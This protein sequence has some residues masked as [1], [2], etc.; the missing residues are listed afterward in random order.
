[1]SAES[2]NDQLDAGVSR[3]PLAGREALAIKARNRTLF[4]LAPD[5]I[6]IA[7]PQSNY[8]DANPG[9]CQ[10]LGYTRSELVGMHATDIVAPDQ[11]QRIGKALETIQSTARYQ[12]EWTFRRKD[13]SVFEADVIAATM[14]DGNLIAMVRDIT[15]QKAHE[16]EIQRISRLYASLS[17]INQAIVSSTSREELLQTACRVLVEFGDF[18][19]AWIGWHDSQT[20]HLLPVAHWGDEDDYLK[21]ITVYA[22][23]RSQ[24]CGPAGTAF[25]EQR[26]YI[27]D[28]MFNDPITLPWREEIHRRGFRAAAVFPLREKGQVCG[29]LAVYAGEAGIFQD[30]EIAL[31]DEA[32]GNVSHAL[33]NLARLHGRQASE[34]A[35]RRERLFSD[36]MID[37][38]PG[39]LYY[40]DASG[41][42]LRWNQNFETVTGYSGAEIARMHPSD[43]FT[44][45]DKPR[46]A[47][48]IAAVFELGEASVEADFVAK[49]GTCTP[50]L[51]T[52]RRVEV[53]GAPCLVGVGID[54]SERKHA[55]DRLNESERQYRELV[56]HANSIILHWSRDGHVIFL[57]EFGQRFFGYTEDEIRGRHVIGTIVPELDAGGRDLKPLMDEICA[58]PAAFEQNSNENMRRNG[59]RVWIAWTNKVALDAQGQVTEILSI[60]TDITAQKRAEDELRAAQASLEQRVLDRTA[61]LAKAMHEAEAA[62]RI[63]SAF[64]ATMSHELR[65]PLNSIIGFTG[66]VLQGLAGPLNPE[67]SKQL[68]MVRTSAHH[69]LELISDVLD[70]SKIEAGQLEVRAEP[71]DLRESLERVVASMTPLAEKKGVALDLT[72]AADIACMVGD[73]RRVEQILINLLGNAVKFTE[74]GRVRVTAESLPDVRLPPEHAVQAVLRLQVEDTG[75]GIK[76][77]DLAL[78]FQPFQQID[79]GLTRRHDGSG[80]GLAICHRLASLMGGTVSV[81]SQWS[82]GSRF[83][84]MLPLGRGSQP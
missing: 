66:L 10:M 46:V 48:R 72:I 11:I 51:F 2:A 39:V 7:D 59:E 31:L 73:R 13:G 24:G 61:A 47:R 68:G 6:L 17:H 8:V 4:D 15:V 82:I 32:A 76:P 12:R 28:D 43:F 5:G 29:I 36:T 25:R 75:M 80:L 78:L 70:I 41:R 19:M 21:T 71:F 14:P 9:I 83:T 3:R 23:D 58:N 74:R 22:D 52:G 34:E 16:R 79:V 27:C 65:T 38:V 64:L 63:K 1:M 26:P 57:N 77:S 53:E 56:K 84:V 44:E 69:L 42:F 60:G 20:Q 45:H 49:D 33:D 67:Q 50:Y 40:Y 35:T 18:K 55:Q 81:E 54:I 62:D 30:R 37:S